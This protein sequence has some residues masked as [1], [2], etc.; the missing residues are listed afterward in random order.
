[1][2]Y[3]IVY[4]PG[5]A[6]IAGRPASQQDLGAHRGYLQALRAART[7]LQVAPS[8]DGT[9]WVAVVEAGGETEARGLLA[10]DPAVAAGVVRAELRRW[11]IVFGLNAGA[12]QP[13]PR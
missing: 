1:M 8:G 5:P 6:W 11:H 2:E 9:T 13:G 12:S 4:T 3:A 10:A 7:L